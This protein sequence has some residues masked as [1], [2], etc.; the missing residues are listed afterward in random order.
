MEIIDM[1]FV[2]QVS[3][4]VTNFYIWIYLDI[5]NVICV[6][7]CM[8]VLHIELYLFISLSVTLTIFQDYSNIDHF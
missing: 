1:F 3:G 2:C 4:L 8:M 5:V 6:K 7:L